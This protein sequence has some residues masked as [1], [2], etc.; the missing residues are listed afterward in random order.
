MGLGL[1][2]KAW[3]AEIDIEKTLDLSGKNSRVPIGSTEE[4][5]LEEEEFLVHWEEGDSENP[6][7]FSTMTKWTNAMILAFACFMVSIASSGFSQGMPFKIRLF[8]D[9]GHS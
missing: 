6:M 1:S 4:E 5:L 2:E 9:G 8:F 7:N 3:D